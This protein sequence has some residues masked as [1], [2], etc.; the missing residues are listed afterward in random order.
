MSSPFSPRMTLTPTVGSA[1][2]SANGSTEVT[3]RGGSRRNS[4]VRDV[5]PSTPRAED[6]LGVLKNRMRHSCSKDGL[7]AELQQAEKAGVKNEGLRSSM[8]G[9][10]DHRVNAG[11]AAVRGSGSAISGRDSGK[12]VGKD[13]PLKLMIPQSK[14]VKLGQ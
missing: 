9:I 8:P 5:S 1:I 10:S 14:M 11:S 13:V 12:D 6:P 2:G 7:L 3:P 4:I